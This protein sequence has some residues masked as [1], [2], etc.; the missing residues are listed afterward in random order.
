[1]RLYL[2]RHADATENINGS[3]PHDDL[4][5]ISSAGRI[6]AGKFFASV[7]T[8]LHDMQLIL[9][10]PLIR[11]VQTAE[12]LSSSI[13]FTGNILLKD[14]LRNEWS[15][16]ETLALINSHAGSDHVAL[17]GH[18]PK[19]G[20]LLRSICGDATH[21]QSLAKCGVAIV[22]FDTSIQTGRLLAYLDPKSSVA[23]Q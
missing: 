15:I 19:S 8:S 22:D 18:E 13:G 3:A 14:E 17:V 6:V 12:I 5:C 21:P 23:A 7:K 2:I 10:S 4:R 16:A 1:M 11:A 9:T 20:I